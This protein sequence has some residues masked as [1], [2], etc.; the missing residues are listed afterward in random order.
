MCMSLY[1]QFETSLKSVGFPHPAISA[2]VQVT[3]IFVYAVVMS[4]HLQLPPLC[5]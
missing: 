3:I 2:R 5:H 4:P 1:I